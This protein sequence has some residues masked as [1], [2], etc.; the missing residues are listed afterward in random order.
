M[1]ARDFDDAISIKT[2]ESGDF[3][4]GVHIADVANYVKKGSALDKE[5]RRRANSTYLVGEV[6]P[7]LP[8]SISSGLCSLVEGEDRLVK[9]LIFR[10]SSNIR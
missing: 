7:M 9:S 1:D 6:V 8:H 3:E 10:F 4:I 2:L 5:A